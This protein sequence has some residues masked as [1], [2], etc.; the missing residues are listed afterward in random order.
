MKVDLLCLDSIGGDESHR[1]PILWLKQIYSLLL[2]SVTV[3]LVG[4]SFKRPSVR[5]RKLKRLP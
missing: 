3:H 4:L 1:H 2:M 5:L